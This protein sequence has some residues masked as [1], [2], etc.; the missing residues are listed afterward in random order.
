M[1]SVEQWLKFVSDRA[2]QSAL[3]KGKR[4][5]FLKIEVFPIALPFFVQALLRFHFSTNFTL[6]FQKYIEEMIKMIDQVV[7]HKKAFLQ[8]TSSQLRPPHTCAKIFIRSELFN[9]YLS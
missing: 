3:S 1:T 8:S 7:H 2:T 4:E 9:V 6:R 5:D